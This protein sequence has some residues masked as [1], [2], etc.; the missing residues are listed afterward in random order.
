ME[1]KN[2]NIKNLSLA[3]VFV[4]FLLL[5][6]CTDLEVP[7][8]S[9]L[10]PE[11]FPTEAAH[12][13][14]AKGP[15]YGRL[16]S[17]ISS[18]SYWRIQTLTTDDH[19]LPARAGNW[20]D[21]GQ[22]RE[23]H[24]HT[25]TVDHVWADNT[26]SFGFSGITACNQLLSLFADQPEG[27]LKDA[28]FAEIRMMR[29]FFYYIMMDIFGNVPIMKTFDE[30]PATSP[31]A[32]VFNFIESEVLA[33]IPNLPEDVN[34]ETYG[35]PTKWMAHALLHRMYLNAQVYTGQAKWN[36]AIQQAD[37]VIN[38]GKFALDADFLSMFKP[39]N[40]PQIR[41][42]IFAVVV[43]AFQ[44]EGGIYSR[45]SI[46]SELS[47]LKYGMGT[48]SV[49]NAHRM[50]PEMF[51]KFDWEKNTGGQWICTTQDVRNQTI[52]I[53]PQYDSKGNPI[54]IKTTY[55]KLNEEYNG[56]TPAKDTTWHL[57]FSKE[58]WLRG[59]PAKMDCA[60]DLTS[61]FMG[62][63]SVKFYPDP[64]WNPTPRYEN[65]DFPFFRLAEVIMGKAE[66]IMRGG[67]PT[68]GDT[69]LSLINQVR[70]RAHAA[71]YTQGQLTLDELLDEYAREFQHEAHRRT[72]LIRFGKFH[73]PR[74]F[75]PNVSESYRQL[76]PVPSNQMNL[77]PKLTQNPGY[78]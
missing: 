77:N 24:R 60:N 75:R 44:T 22:F 73:E 19:V 67:T 25:W 12:Y 55:S 48:R 10:V 64:N 57:S 23:A 76:F 78:N 69:P 59:D 18:G 5:V 4:S 52:L 17:D 51:E 3:A 65:H 33:V 38:S 42:F 26:W 1:I 49:S 45:Y 14:A 39:D 74:L 47:N 46:S 13:D 61:Q 7:V 21:G 70:A 72:D 35:R 68:G 16:A 54:L 32:E 63:R 31:R 27:P 58:I 50:Q 28:Q 9:E 43:D 15:I 34:V 11:N 6:A 56:P 37:F 29:A 2:I 62:A 36:E 53:G 20:D 30:D 8:E 71:L 41:E 40:G 66:A